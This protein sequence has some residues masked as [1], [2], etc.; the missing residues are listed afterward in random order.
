[1]NR[2]PL[3]ELEG[4]GRSFDPDGRTGVH[5]VSFRI[6]HGEFVAIIGPS[7]AGK[8]TL[9]NIM[10]L[11]DRFDTGIVRFNGTDIG[12]LS[13]PQRDELRAKQIG[14]VF[15]SSFVLGDQSALHNAALGLR[16]RGAPL[17]LRTR[18]AFTALE[19]VGIAQR[20]NVE[21]R[22]LSG[23][24][25]QRLAIARATAGRPALILADELT[26]NLDSE[27]GARVLGQLR[28]LNSNGTTVVVITHDATIAAAADRQIRIVDGHATEL[29][30][31]QPDRRPETLPDPLPSPPKG[32]R[33]RLRAI[34]D[35]CADAISAMSA[36]A[37]RSTLLVL[38]F[39]LGVSGLV[40]AAGLSETAATQ[41]S[42]RLTHAALDEVRIR[43]PGGA[44]LLNLED[45]RLATWVAAL[46]ELPHVT[47]V[48]FV[49]TAPAT[50]A[51]LRRLPGS[52]SP[53]DEYFLVTA[54]AEYIRMMGGSDQ[55]A[56]SLDLLGSS[57]IR[58]GAWVGADA[59]TAFE[60]APPG[61]GS[62]MW[63][64]SRRVDVLGS[65]EA[66]DR[67]PQLDRTVVVTRDILE[68]LTE[69][70]VTIVLRTEPGYPA[71]VA[72]AAPLALD[73]GSPGTFDVETVADL[74]S[75]RFGVANDLGA[76]VGVL[77]A[78][79]LALAA[80]SASTTMYLSVQARAPE[81]ALRRALGASKF[82]VARLF[83]AEGVTIGIAGGGL[84]ALIGTAVALVL[85]MQRSWTPVLPP[86]IT[87]LALGLGL[88]T[89]LVSSIVP[90]WLAS[91]YQPAQAI[92]A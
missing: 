32:W 23:G 54:S 81:I 80:I 71:V 7:G 26:G 44:G 21:G 16:V 1:M 74:R 34:A 22:W 15:Q 20:W 2:R 9:L 68:G 57:N 46:R 55:A 28:A 60:L 14:F 11:L 92:R 4:V 59:E 69:V 36:R 42:E 79:L 41:V 65:F 78:I 50:S 12:T 86:H 30:S 49:A 53:P 90:A 13:E 43:A 64:G 84:G 5:G 72:D 39:T 24:E 52:M 82:D 67:E 89:G 47:E 91:R 38:A 62:T 35:D 73:P 61:P 88:A 48:G 19:D 18:L 77:S 75:L 76:F 70:G 3:L 37:L 6:H 85:A 29:A 45:E 33:R 56:A 63:I 31:T 83:V 51:N 66:G 40:A 10:G 27:N 58:G 17:E 8:S 87:A 25:R